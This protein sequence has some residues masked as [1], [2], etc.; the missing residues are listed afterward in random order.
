MTV[1]NA[2]RATI[3]NTATKSNAVD[4]FE[5][6]L[7]GLI[8]PAA[9]TAADITF[10]GSND[11]TGTYY[12]VKKCDGSTTPI[13]AFTV[14]TPSALDYIIFDPDSFSGLRYIK[15]VSSAAQGADRILTLLGRSV[16]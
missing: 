12:P 7:C 13:A 8:M 10:E 9:W 2:G 3:L 15:I 4:L 1:A 11:L 6:V 16:S 14:K 5:R